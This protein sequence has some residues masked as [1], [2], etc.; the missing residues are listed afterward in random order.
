MV[1]TQTRREWIKKAIMGVGGIGVAVSG[2]DALIPS[3]ASASDYWDAGPS[4]GTISNPMFE[5]Y[6]KESGY[7]LF[8]DKRFKEFEL[9]IL[10]EGYDAISR[11][12]QKVLVPNGELRRKSNYFASHLCES[13]VIKTE[14]G[15]ELRTIINL[16]PSPKVV[17]EFHPELLSAFTHEYGHAWFGYM[18]S[19]V[20]EG[21]IEKFDQEIKNQKVNN[22]I[23]NKILHNNPQSELQANAFSSHILDERKYGILEEGFKI[24]NEYVN[25]HEDQR[26]ML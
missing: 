9:E 2:I 7:K 22:K 26:L 3:V 24:Y 12:L 19:C 15:L 4:C 20:K 10:K 8:L 11:Y 18:R 25:S 21:W 16:V 13:T 6:E 14:R 17:N 1:K 23:S 5:K